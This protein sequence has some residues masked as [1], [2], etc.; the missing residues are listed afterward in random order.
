MKKLLFVIFYPL[1]CYAQQP[2][3][4]AFFQE[5]NCNCENYDNEYLFEFFGF[6]VE[7]DV[8]PAV[9]AIN[10][11][12]K[13]A[14][15][16]ITAQDD[17]GK[18]TEDQYYQLKTKFK[19]GQYKVYIEEI[20]QRL[21]AK[22]PEQA[23][24]FSHIIELQ[25]N[26]SDQISGFISGESFAYHRVYGEFI[27]GRVRDENTVEFSILWSEEGSTYNAGSCTIEIINDSTLR[28]KSD[29]RYFY[30]A[31]GTGR[32]EFLYNYSFVP[33]DGEQLK[34]SKS[35]PVQATIQYED[36]T[37]SSPMSAREGFAQLKSN[38]KL[39]L[40]PGRV[41]LTEPLK[42][43]G[44]GNFQIIGD[45]TSIVAK[46]DMP[47]VQ[48]YDTHGVTLNGLLI[49]HEIG[50]WCAHN[51]IEFYNAS[52]LRI[53]ACTFD[54]SGYF[55]LSLYEVRNATIEN[56]MFF[57]CEFGLAAWRSRDLI[58]RNNSF[59]KNR[60]DNIKTND[61]SQFTNDV[62]SENFFE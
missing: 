2:S 37:Y 47:V 21:A 12:C 48:F 18:S 29:G 59:S 5:Y 49:V 14:R 46:I 6:D 60:A 7:D 43:S 19:R 45:K 54:G 42:L 57:N 10:S 31:S 8:T 39:Y 16:E 32:D 4:E 33:S 53:E 44:I 3:I 15:A 17:Y 52:K 11:F 50:K 27:D 9:E 58:V 62:Y 41:E 24:D 35:K 26:I 36:G 13:D 61:I 22:Y 20:D 25:L 56:N 23:N 30:I 40:S 55:G 34:I 28:F 38:E 1:L 51:C